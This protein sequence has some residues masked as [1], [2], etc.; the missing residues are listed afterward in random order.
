[1]ANL[2]FD[3][4]NPF[5]SRSPASVAKV[6][7]PR[8]TSSTASASCMVTKFFKRSS[9]AMIHVHVGQDAAFKSCCLHTGRYDGSQRNHYFRE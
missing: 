8:H 7:R 4:E 2:S 9:V 5:F 6:S 3:Q 1:M